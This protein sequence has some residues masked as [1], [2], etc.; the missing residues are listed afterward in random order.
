MQDVVALMAHTDWLPNEYLR[1]YVLKRGHRRQLLGLNGTAYI[2]KGVQ[3]F[4]EQKG[5]SSLPPV[6]LLHIRKSG[7]RRE[8]RLAR[9]F[10]SAGRQSFTT[11]SCDCVAQRSITHALDNVHAATDVVHPPVLSIV[12]MRRL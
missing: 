8:V 7:R 9:C 5:R 4:L 12:I 3:R 2:W 1:W 11:S 10:E 6:T